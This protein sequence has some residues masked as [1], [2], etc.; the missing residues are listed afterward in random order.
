MMHVKSLSHL[1]PPEICNPQYS[2]TVRPWYCS[3]QGFK[4]AQ[5]PSKFKHVQQTV[6]KPWMRF[7]HTS[8]LGKEL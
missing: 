3:N 1:L 5:I 8:G 6:H 2:G 4:T 7:S